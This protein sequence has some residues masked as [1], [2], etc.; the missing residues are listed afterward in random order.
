VV[1]QREGPDSEPP[2]WTIVMVAAGGDAEAAL[3][4]LVKSWE[5]RWSF[6]SPD[7]HP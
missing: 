7:S 5:E 4:D 6:K 3:G 2:F 1:W